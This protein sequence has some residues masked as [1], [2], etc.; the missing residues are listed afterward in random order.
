MSQLKLYLVVFLCILAC[1]FVAKKYHLIKFFDIIFSSFLLFS[2]AP[3][4]T[5][6]S[7]KI[8]SLKQDI[9]ILNTIL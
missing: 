1:S 2:L 6:W 4:S 9:N 3:N 8:L 7:L 5:F